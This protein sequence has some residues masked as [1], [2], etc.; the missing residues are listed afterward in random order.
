MAAIARRQRWQDVLFHRGTQAFAVARLRQTHQHRRRQRRLVADRHQRSVATAGE[1]LAQRLAALLDAHLLIDDGNHGANWNHRRAIEWA[2]E[3]P[4]RVVVV[5][6][7]AMP[8]DLFFTSV[9][10]WLNRFPE[11]LVSFYLGTGRP[12]QYQMQVA[13]RLIVADN[14]IIA[15]LYCPLVLAV[16]T[17]S[18]KLFNMNPL[19]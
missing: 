6:D 17:A 12:P 7:D 19:D 16:E 2:A 1:D 11:S 18:A 9:T 15:S 14:K 10:S 8:V 13:E 3:Q 4:C 5:E